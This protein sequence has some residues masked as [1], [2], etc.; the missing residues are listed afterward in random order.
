MTQ[1][2]T[3]AG[4]SDFGGHDQ[5]IQTLTNAREGIVEAK[6][7]NLPK[8]EVPDHF[9]NQKG[10]CGLS[11]KLSLESAGRTQRHNGETPLPQA[12]GNPGNT[13]NPNNSDMRNVSIKKSTEK[14]LLK[15]TDFS[16][17]HEDHEK[18]QFKP[19]LSVQL[20]STASC[21]TLSMP[22]TSAHYNE[23]RHKKSSDQNVNG[24]STRHKKLGLT[25]RRHPFGTSSSSQHQQKGDKE[26][27]APSH[28]LPVSDSDACTDSASSLFFTS[29]ISDTCD[30]WTRKSSTCWTSKKLPLQAVE[31]FGEDEISQGKKG[32]TNHEAKAAFNNIK[33]YKFVQF[34]F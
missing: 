20:Q 1:K 9:V 18:L 7:L 3:T 11:R 22:G 27:L 2:F 33:F 34:L 29:Q 23:R 24:F 10:L 12:V 25:G 28:N 26:N 19:H 5:E 17:K 6:E 4:A 15:S 32:Y 14:P 21:Q 30:A 31:H 16:Q 8:S 13:A